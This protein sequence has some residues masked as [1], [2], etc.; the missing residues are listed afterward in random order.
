[1]TCGWRC[2]DGTL[3]AVSDRLGFIPLF[4]WSEGEKLLL[5]DSIRELAR[6]LPRVRFDDRAV[7]AYL[8][9][10]YYIGDTTLLDGVR[11]LP[12]DSTLIWD[13]TLAMR[14]KTQHP[15]AVFAGNR[16]EAV[17]EY[18]RLFS[19][20][21]STRLTP[22][23]G[24]LTLSGGRDSRHILLELHRQGALPH[25]VVTL[26]RRNSTDDIA[27]ADLAE[28][29]GLRCIVA[30]G[31]LDAFEVEAVKNRMNFYMADENGWYVHLLDH[32]DGPVFD[33]L[34][35]D[36]L[37]N[38]LYF[39]GEVAD[40]IDT[41]AFDDA[42]RL[43]VRKHGGYLSYLS[44]EGRQ[45]F[46]DELAEDLISQEFARHR[47]M[48]NPVQS[49][50]FWNRTRREIAL[51]PIGMARSRVDTLLPYTDPDLLAFF[52]SLPHTV[53]GRQ[54]FHDEVIGKAYPSF[55]D[56]A[57]AEKRKPS[58][59][60]SERIV[61]SVRA[62]KKLVGRFASWPR[63]LSYAGAVVAGGSLKPLENPF[64]RLYPLLQAR[65]ELGIEL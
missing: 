52:L 50:V 2:T 24:R 14:E 49:F 45:R 35:G 42:A 28:R 30:E 55:A 20:A 1:M 47:G 56:V 5:S 3:E 36:V 19:S 48:A 7:A 53:F 33:G 10:G 65:D 25:D 41:G 32:L 40:L 62:S 17:D 27:A 58:Y 4:Y 37:S 29:L 31:V 23:I 54:G 26:R 11:V 34:A 8:R 63:I 61:Y 39:V 12:P 13:G 64:S 59:R 21:I 22:Q 6:R 15:P 18:I 46:S 16:D 43:F 51:L 38:G 44:D 57:F 60:F 9:L